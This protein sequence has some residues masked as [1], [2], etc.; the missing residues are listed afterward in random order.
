MPFIESI[1]KHRSVSIIGM[2]KNCGKTVVLNYILSRLS[3][4]EDCCVA[5]TSIGVDGEK[6]DAVTRTAKPEI[7]IF[8]GMMFATSQTHYSARRLV[9]EILDIGKDAT[10]LG[11]V[12]IA[13]VLDGGKVM[14]SG[15]GD[16][17]SLVRLIDKFDELGSDIVLVDGALSRR[18]LASPSVTE[19]IV[20]CTGA[21][22]SLNIEELTS[23]TLHAYRMISLPV[24]EYGSQDV[25][26]DLES[27]QSGLWEIRRGK[28][29]GARQ[30]V[31]QSDDG[32]I[33]IL[34]LGVNSAVGIEK[35][36]DK[37][38]EITGVLF[39]AGMVTDKAIE[40]LSSCENIGQIV[41]RDFTRIFISPLVY[42]KFTDRGGKISVLRGCKLEAICIN[43]VSP[44][45]YK[46]DGEKLA[47][48]L[49]AVTGL[50][51]YDVK[52]L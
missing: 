5:V 39:F 1:L 9:S 19:A 8:N 42:R 52:N 47:A 31:E 29:A 49:A 23:K 13:K 30:G 6:T 22:L 20:L 27:K 15:P 37:L 26:A 35:Y 36:R 46:L 25:R 28:P 24:F 10:V 43:P 51:I 16:T 3:N 38:L 12:V 32:R 18:S 21:A 2:E 48:K 34:A 17:P 7:T 44:T 40:T 50:K 4:S 14:L 11:K 41:V 33:E 45:G